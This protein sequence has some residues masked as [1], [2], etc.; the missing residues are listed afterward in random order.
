MRNA[1]KKKENKVLMSMRI[2]VEDKE[3][4]EK[5][6]AYHIGVYETM[7]FGQETALLWRYHPFGGVFHA[8]WKDW[9]ESE[10][11]SKAFEWWWGFLQRLL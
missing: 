9:L 2:S 7:C 1:D 10:S 8:A 6:W 11:N 4:I 5:N 3:L